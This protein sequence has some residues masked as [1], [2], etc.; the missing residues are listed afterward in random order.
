MKNLRNL[1]AATIMAGALL[2]SCK[3]ENMEPKH[4]SS[5]LSGAA[6]VDHPALDTV[7]SRSD[8]LFL[9]REDDKSPVVNK[10]YT[11]GAPSPCPSGQPSWGN[12]VMT[13][14][15]YQGVNYVDFVFVLAPSWYSDFNNWKFGIATDFQFEPDGTPIITQDW[16]TSVISPPENRWE[17]RFPVSE[18][19]SPCFNVAV[20]VNVLKMNLFGALIQGSETSLW[21]QNPNWDVPGHSAQS[22][23]PYLMRFCPERCLEPMDTTLTGGCCRGCQSSNT[24]TFETGNPNCVYVTSCKNLNNVVLVD[25]NG[26]HHMFDGLTGRNGTFCHPS[27]LPVTRV[28]VK[29]GCF[30]SNEGPGYGRRF[31]NPYAV[32]D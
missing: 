8:T 25:C 6:Q 9:I 11:A 22:T 7:C 30:H 19:P 32:C 27:G 15:Y 10:C 12:L 20:R 31:D 26:T 1:L 14:G 3:P 23:S 29:S 17:L 13:E 2:Y 21:S 4:N 18:L 28:Y 16:G 24:V 5:A